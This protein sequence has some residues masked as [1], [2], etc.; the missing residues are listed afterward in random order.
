MLST[1]PRH[2]APRKKS[3][4]AAEE[5]K[6]SL[7]SASGRHRGEEKKARKAPEPEIDD[8]DSSY[9]DYDETAPR[10]RAMRI[11]MGV[12]SLIGLHSL[13]TEDL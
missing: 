3:A 8:Y 6:E 7:K 2:K 11:V 13:F 5:E 10:F 4:R 1:D 9:D 12:L